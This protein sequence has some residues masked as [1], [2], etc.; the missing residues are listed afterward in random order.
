MS[1]HGNPLEVYPDG[2]TEPI[3]A[4]P[5]APNEVDETYSDLEWDRFQ[6]FRLLPDGRFESFDTVL[7]QQLPAL[8]RRVNDR[9]VVTTYW[10]APYLIAAIDPPAEDRLV[11]LDAA[12]VAGRTLQ[13]DDLPMDLPRVLNRQ[14]PV[15]VTSRP[16][17][18]ASI[19]VSLSRHRPERMAGLSPPAVAEALAGAD[20]IAAGSARLDVQSAQS[21][22]LAADLENPDGCCYGAL[23]PLVQAGQPSYDELPDGG[24]RVR[25]ID[26]DPGVYGVPQ[27]I[28]F[29]PWLSA[30]ISFRPLR[31]LEVRAVP[32]ARVPGWRPVGIFDPE[33][34]T[35]F[36]NLSRV[37]L[38]TYEPPQANGTDE[39]SR[40]ALR[41]Q[42][43]LPSGN[44]GGYLNSPPLLLTNFASLPKLLEHATGPQRDAPISALRV[45]VADVDGYSERSAER[46][47][48]VAQRIAEAT[49]LD[50]DITLGSSPAPQTVEL[51]AG[52]F[53]RPELRLARP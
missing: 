25:G 34:L 3:C 33:R 51:P 40:T 36:A 24:L 53:G 14:F 11:G 23:S 29:R 46:V 8:K 32:G 42:P 28:A 22:Q 16:Y 26:P 9:L 47:R 31:Q 6:P 27:H 21:A 37:P 15:L 18:D 13:A 49:G 12:M 7:D 41:N 4:P 48:L 39:R 20:R 45:R 44:P 2:R 10:Y 35:Q 38:E 19:S 17:V 50:V 52:S 43:L 1:S 30:D 5:T